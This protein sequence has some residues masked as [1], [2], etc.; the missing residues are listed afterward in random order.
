MSDGVGTVGVGTVGFGARRGRSF[1]RITAYTLL[2]VF[3]VSALPAFLPLPFGRS[4]ALLNGLRELVERSTLPVVA[5]VFLYQGFADGALPAL[6]ECRLALGLR[7]L[8]PLVALGYLL[9]AVAIVAVSMQVTGDGIRQF[10][11]QRQGNQNL[12]SS[13]RSRLI[14]TPDVPRLR[15]VLAEQPAFRSL[16]KDPTAVLGS[17]DRPLS[18]QR[19]AAMALMDRAEVDLQAQYLRSRADLTGRLTSQ[20]IRL[21]LT[22]LA[23]GGFYLLTG[24]LWPR[25]DP[26]LEERVRQS[27]L[28]CAAEEEIDQVRT[29]APGG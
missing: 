5:L 1:L 27:R 15:A 22:S 23:Y 9:I 21:G 4:E 16:L 25:S 29:D 12:V 6:W 3:V 20:A 17:A 24:L 10:D 11:Q 7:L 14:A 2:L 18:M 8:L 13:F 26:D 19:Q 28:S